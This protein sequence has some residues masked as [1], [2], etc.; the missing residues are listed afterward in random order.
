VF[1]RKWPT[2]AKVYLALSAVSALAAFGLARGYAHRLEALH[3]A[4][5]RSVP[6]VLAA[7]N[8]PRGSTISSATVEIGSMPSVYAPPGV[9]GDV[10]EVEGRTAVAD[11]AA[12]EPITRTRVSSPHVGPVA[13]LV[14]LGLRAFAIA[15]V[16]PQDAVRAGDRVDV[17]AT[18][19]GG[20]PH[21]ETVAIGL[22]VLLVLE[23]TAAGLDGSAANEAPRLVLLVAPD[24]AER[25]AYAQAFGEITVTIEGSPAAAAG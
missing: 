5:G 8:I 19:G 13:A 12:G 9:F 22:E 2:V 18:Y 10:A 1:R 23:P 21:T 15:A 4:V 14:P 20:H 6:V 3:P 17:L 7:G 25:L 11:L 24:A 16:V